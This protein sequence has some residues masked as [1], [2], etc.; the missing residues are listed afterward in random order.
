M[1][2]SLEQFFAPERVNWR[3]RVLGK[4]CKRLGP[5]VPIVTWA[6]VLV[7]SLPDSYALWLMY[8]G[9][10]LYVAYCCKNLPQS[11]VHKMQSN[12]Y[13]KGTYHFFFKRI[14]NILDA[15]FMVLIWHSLIS[16]L[17]IMMFRV[18]VMPLVHVLYLSP[19]NM[20]S[21]LVVSISALMGILR[22]QQKTASHSI[23]S[24]ASESSMVDV[25]EKIHLAMEI[26]QSVSKR[27]TRAFC[28]MGV[29]FYNVFFVASSV[30]LAVMGRALADWVRG[31]MV[32]KVFLVS[33]LLTVRVAMA[34]KKIKKEYMVLKINE[35]E[36][37]KSVDDSVCLQQSSQ[38]ED[39]MEVKKE[40]KGHK[41]RSGL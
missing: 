25:Q 14:L 8:V 4:F 37:W 1:R 39:L 29:V 19:L 5:I 12:R 6:C 21:F 2:A 26:N 24:L 41:T 20:A 15:L 7:P 35:I 10:V 11:Y 36:R 32:N 23:K 13:R 28:D 9:Y 17:V 40:V 30:S 33:A 16:L 22:Y 18:S 27:M 38:E 31:A 3:W 34:N